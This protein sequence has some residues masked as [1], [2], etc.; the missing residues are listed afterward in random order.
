MLRVAVKSIS[1]FTSNHRGLDT[2]T[3][4]HFGKRRYRRIHQT[5][6]A[7][8]SATQNAVETCTVLRIL[9][10]FEAGYPDAVGVIG[11]LLTLHQSNAQSNSIALRKSAVFFPRAY[12]ELIRG[13]CRIPPVGS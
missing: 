2:P 6:R 7:E 8:F 9:N 13:L 4:V 3:L 1:L 10:R 11:Y 5:K 12:G